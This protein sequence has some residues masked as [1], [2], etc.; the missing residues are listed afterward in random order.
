M[1]TKAEKQLLLK[2]GNKIKMLR[3]ENNL[4]QFQLSI[5]A[6]IPKNQVGRIERAEINTTILTL[7]KIAKV[8][9]VDIKYFFD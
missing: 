7:S 5:D 6:G 8:F 9:K 1:D 4:S 3:A 2:I